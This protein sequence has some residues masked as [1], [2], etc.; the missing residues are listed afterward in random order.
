MLCNPFYSGHYT[1]FIYFIVHGI[2]FIISFI[3]LIYSRITIKKLYS[4][5]ECRNDDINM[6][7]KYKKFGKNKITSLIIFIYDSLFN[8][9]Y[10]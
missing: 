6:I 7:K 10:I 4:P 2:T 3:L 9:N 1:T 8:Y 5:F